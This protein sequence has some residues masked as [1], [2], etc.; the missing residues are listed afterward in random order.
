[1]AQFTKGVPIPET[2]WN[3]LESVLEANM[4]RMAKDIAATLKKPD[5]PLLQALK[6]DKVRPYI[7]EEGESE[8]N[9]DMRCSFMCQKP[10]APEFVQQCGQ[11][12]LWSGGTAR[13]PEHS[14][15]AQMKYSLPQVKRANLDEANLEDVDAY[16]VSEDNTVYDIDYKPVGSYD[17]EKHQLRRFHIA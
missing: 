7:F 11:P 9:I 2:I 1:M 4:Y 16:F 14:Y 15:Q 3:S 10:S 8:T 17:S 12:I 13:C 5:A 6:K